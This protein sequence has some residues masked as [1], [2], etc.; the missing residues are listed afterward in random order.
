MLESLRDV[1]RGSIKA[2]LSTALS[3]SEKK[4]TGDN[5]PLVAEKISAWPSCS[6]LYGIGELSADAQV[7]RQIFDALAIRGAL[8]LLLLPLILAVKVNGEYP[9]TLQTPNRGLVLWI[10]I[11]L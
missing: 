5:I 9:R 7:L 8:L 11:P 4:W 6:E 3:S 10:R 2:Q 1:P